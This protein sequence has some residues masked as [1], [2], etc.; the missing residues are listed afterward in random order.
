MNQSE[1][2]AH[3]EH[4]ADYP[5]VQGCALVDAETGMVWYHAG[6][7]ADIEQIGEAAIEFWRLQ[8]RLSAQLGNMGALQS[9]AHSFEHCVVAL[10]P[11]HDKPVL[12]LVC[13]ASKQ[14]MAW[15][16]WSERIVDLRRALRAQIDAQTS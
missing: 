16:P 7:L 14:G 10:F 6:A 3:V 1:V 12:V 4:L 13:V 9:T 2:H 8:N 11:C 5:S 15:A